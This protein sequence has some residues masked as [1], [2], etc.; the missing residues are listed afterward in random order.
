ME[1]Q[2]SFKQVQRQDE[3]EMKTINSRRSQ[4]ENKKSD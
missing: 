4:R 3:I 1:N 2:M